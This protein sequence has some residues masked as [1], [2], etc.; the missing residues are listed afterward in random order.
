MTHNLTLA[1]TLTITLTVTLMCAPESADPRVQ[2][3]ERSTYTEDIIE[4]SVTL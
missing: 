4:A 1:L 2:Y 3:R